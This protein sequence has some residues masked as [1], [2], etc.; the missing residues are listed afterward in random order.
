MPLMVGMPSA[1]PKN[2]KPPLIVTLTGPVN[3]FRTDGYEPPDHAWLAPVVSSDRSLAY[4]GPVWGPVMVGLDGGEYR[5]G[6]G[7]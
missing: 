5:Q 4:R 1:N 7:R 2:A 3:T 6:V